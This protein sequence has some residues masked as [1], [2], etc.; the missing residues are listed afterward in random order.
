MSDFAAKGAEPVARSIQ[1]CNFRSA[2]RLSNESARA[3]TTL[4]EALARN[5]MNSLDV[6]LGAGLE[7]RFT[8]LEQLTMEDFRAVCLA[9]CYILP[10]AVRPTTNT[11]LLEVDSGL[12]FTVIDLLLGGTGTKIS[13]SR[14]L[15]EID[16]EIMEGFGA[17]IAHHIEQLW[18]P[19]GFTLIPG[20]C[21]KPNLAHK[22]IPP[23]EKVL[24]IC[25]DVSVAGM[26]GA[27]CI[28]FPASLGSSIVRNIKA[29]P[30]S[31]KG[32]AGYGPLPS[33]QERILDCRFN[34]SGEI[35]RLRVLVRDLATLQ[36][37][38]VLKLPAPV[39]APG[40]LTLESRSFY[41][42]SPVRQGKHKAMQLLEAVAPASW[43][44]RPWLI[45]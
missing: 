26:V 35:P 18:Q 36:V 15:T 2:G 31:N 11:V 24:R 25:F 30:A 21:L 8:S 23:T 12:M 3:L 34:V 4:H 39:D 20:H 40:K 29:D 22:A 33:L 37:G 17:L 38:T 13:G 5:L 44:E 16:E 32:G 41:E 45:R 10:C 1:P 27:L 14:E 6:Y 19:V 43:D 7:V 42:A 9:A 28:S